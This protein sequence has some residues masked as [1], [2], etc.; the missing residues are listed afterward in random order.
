MTYYYKVLVGSAQYH[1]SEALTYASDEDLPIGAIVR[2]PLQR[3][4]ALGVVTGIV[5]K[6]SFKTKNILETFGLPPLP[7]NLV[8]VITWLRAYYPA[9]LGQTTLSILPS[10][11]TPKLIDE[12]PG[13]QE[14]IAIAD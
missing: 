7:A 1:G 12:I 3:I 4:S 10:Q 5:G 9:P 2:I 8:G 14:P 13:L 11:L 6:P